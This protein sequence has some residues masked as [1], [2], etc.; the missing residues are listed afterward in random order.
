MLSFTVVSKS[1][2]GGL[3]WTWTGLRTGFCDLDSGLLPD[4]ELVNF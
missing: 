3:D 1:L 4:V 2:F